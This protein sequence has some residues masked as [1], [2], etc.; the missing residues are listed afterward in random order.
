M[1][2]QQI[3]LKLQL[4]FEHRP[5]PEPDELVSSDIFHFEAEAVKE[6]L[7]RMDRWELTTS[8]IKN[9]LTSELWMLTPKAFHYY[10]PALLAK[11]LE[12]YEALTLFAN[13]VVDA[14]IRPEVGDANKILNRFNSMTEQE[15]V[16]V[17]ASK[18]HD[19]YDS[20]WPDA[21]FLHR[22]GTLSQEEG[23]AV[24][25]FI[26]AFRE[27]HGEDFPFDELDLAILRFWQRFCSLPS[28][29]W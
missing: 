14:L 2:I 28:S 8:D 25:A 17:A 13:E 1:S 21:I 6:L 11:L 15:L 22:F 12:D 29:A 18:L 4:A 24:L 10:L 16:R 23:E 3:R 20:A 7:A 5:R 26:L 9:V 27:A 19:W